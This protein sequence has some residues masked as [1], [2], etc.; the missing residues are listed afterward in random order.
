MADEKKSNGYVSVGLTVTLISLVA[1]VLGALIS[2]VDT[3]RIADRDTLESK[4]TS[5]VDVY[6]RDLIHVQE[7]GSLKDNELSSDINGIKVWLKEAS[8]RAERADAKLD[9]ALQREMR[10]LNATMEAKLIHL[11]ARLQ[12]EIARNTDERRISFERVGKS[13]DFLN[14]FVGTSNTL[15][16]DHAARIKALEEGK[17]P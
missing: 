3:S 15:D 12:G 17:R 7:F 16:A 6:R 14:D 9:E 8:D 4:L 5:N 10:L 1:T 13:I 2:G 11:D